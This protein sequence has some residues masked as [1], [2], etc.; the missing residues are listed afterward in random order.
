MTED[1]REQ[2]LARIEADAHQQASDMA[3]H[4]GE[5]QASRDAAV[6]A[7]TRIREALDGALTASL[8]RFRLSG[9]SPDAYALHA[10][11]G[12]ILATS[13]EAQR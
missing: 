7:L 9:P 8:L 13:Q 10:A 12:K 2:R 1:A 3:T 11:L 6:A 4:L 5:V